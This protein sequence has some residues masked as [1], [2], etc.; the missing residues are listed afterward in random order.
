MGRAHRKSFE[1]A[2][3]ADGQ[4]DVVAVSGLSQSHKQCEGRMILK[5]CPPKRQGESF[6]YSLFEQIKTWEK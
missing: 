4:R 3:E 2:T 6:I 5:E 1:R